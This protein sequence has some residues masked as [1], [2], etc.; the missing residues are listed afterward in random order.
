LSKVADTGDHN[1]NPPSLVRLRDGRL[2]VAYGYRREPFGMRAKLSLNEGRSWGEEIVLRA[3]GRTWDIGYPRMVQRSD[4]KLVTI[5]YH[6]T[7]A[8]PEQH[9]AASIW[10]PNQLG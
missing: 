6:T 7:T 1:G 5:Y 10:D 4:G 3:D 2:C 9:I 8:N